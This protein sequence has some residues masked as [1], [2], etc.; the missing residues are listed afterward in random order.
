MRIVKFEW[1]LPCKGRKEKLK[2]EDSGLGWGI[3]LRLTIDASRN[4]PP[5]R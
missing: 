4:N 3:H 1:S 2:P 5:S